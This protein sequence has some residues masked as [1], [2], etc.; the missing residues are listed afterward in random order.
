M[1]FARIVTHYVRHNAWLEDGS[2]LRDAG[3]IADISGIMVNGRLTF[4]PR[5]GG[6]GTSSACGHA[7]SL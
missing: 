3:A 7:Q 1:A 2:L 4:R 6:R 5:S